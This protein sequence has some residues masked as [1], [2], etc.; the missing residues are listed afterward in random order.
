LFIDVSPSGHLFCADR[1]AKGCADLFLG[2]SG[3]ALIET[4]IFNLD[5]EVIAGAILANLR[6]RRTSCPPVPVVFSTSRDVVED[7]EL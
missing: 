7:P 2:A 6:A 5:C 1:L 3:P 4:G